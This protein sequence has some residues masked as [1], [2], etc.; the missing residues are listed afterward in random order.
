MA[1]CT[2]EKGMQRPE[3]MERRYEG[4]KV[5]GEVLDMREKCKGGSVIERKM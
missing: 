3:E 2:R 4:K 1:T 5:M